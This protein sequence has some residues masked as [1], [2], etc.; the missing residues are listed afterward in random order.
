MGLEKVNPAEK[1]FWEY[2]D[3]FIYHTAGASQILGN[4]GKPGGIRGDT[5]RSPLC[6]PQFWDA[7]H[8][9]DV[10]DKSDVL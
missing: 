4:W 7:P 9:A 3:E 5:P 6:L 8:T 10:L 2:R 1:L